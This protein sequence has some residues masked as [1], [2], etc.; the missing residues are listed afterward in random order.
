MTEYLLFDSTHRNRQL[1]SNPSDYTVTVSAPSAQTA[2][3]SLDPYSNSLP[4][5]TGTTLL[6]NN[7]FEVNVQPNSTW[8]GLTGFYTNYY[9]NI[10]SYNGSSAEYV[11]QSIY[12]QPPKVTQ[13]VNNNSGITLTLET[14][15]PLT[16]KLIGGIKNNVLNNLNIDFSL[17]YDP[18][19]FNIVNYD[20]GLLLLLD[21]SSFTTPNFLLSIDNGQ[22]FNYITFPVIPSSSYWSSSSIHNQYILLSLGTTSNNKP[23]YLSNN[24][25]L[26]FSLFTFPG[27]TGI[28]DT[29]IEPLYG[30]FMAFIDSTKTLVYVSTNY[31]ITWSVISTVFANIQ[32]I[33]I[34]EIGRAHV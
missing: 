31:G 12:S 1:Y 7:T 16:R 11:F 14:T 10:T 15:E 13:Y 27:I 32:Y 3:S 24:Y 30:M 33:Y 6:S 22:R 26:T 19:K 20:N 29:S 28:I 23:L 18:Y 9:F 34:S 2:S 5:Q 8:V 25:G 17:L 4:S 21:T